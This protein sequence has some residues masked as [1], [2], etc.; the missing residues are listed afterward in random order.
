MLHVFTT[1]YIPKIK[2]W[3]EKYYYVYVEVDE[4]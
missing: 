3:I 1:Y 2:P 4:E